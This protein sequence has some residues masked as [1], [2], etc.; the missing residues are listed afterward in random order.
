MAI[1]FKI[2]AQ[3]KS[4]EEWK[5]FKCKMHRRSGACDE[6]Q[7]GFAAPDA[8][9]NLKVGDAFEMI[10]DGVRRFAGTVARLP[11]KYS[12]KYERAELVAKSP[13]GDLESVVFQQ[14]WMKSG[15]G[16]LSPIKRSKV[17]LGQ[18]VD[19]QKIGVGNQLR[20]ILEYAVSCGANISIGD[21]SLDAPMLLDEAKDLSCS[22]AI[23]RVLKWAP[24]NI[25]Y[26]DYSAQGAPSINIKRRGA[27][28]AKTL[29]TNSGKIKDV[30]ITPRED[31]RISGVSVKYE[32]ENTAEDNTWLD[33]V[34]DKY[35][36]DFNSTS[37]N[38]LVMSVELAGSKAFCQSYKIV[39]ETIQPNSEAWWRK[40]V[41]VLKEG[42][43]F[44]VVSS[45]RD[46]SSLPR[47]LVSGSISSRMN[48]KTETDRV[49]ATIR[50][51]DENGSISTREIAVRLVATNA[52]TGTYDI[53]TASQY[54]EPIPTGL[55]KAIYDA[56]G[57]L[58]FDGQITV[59]G[60][61]SED[62]MGFSVNVQSA[63]NPGWASMNSAVVS[64]EE[65]VFKS[66]L[67]IKFGPPKHLYPDNIAELFRISRPRKVPQDA[68]SRSSG[69]VGSSRVQ[70]DGLSPDTNGAQGDSKYSRMVIEGD[71]E[72]HGSIDLNSDSL[73]A[74]EK[75]A[76][77]EILLCK[78]GKLAKAKVIMT[79]PVFLEDGQ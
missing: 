46:D 17:V 9:E 18:S 57:Q 29:A 44:S 33:V 53:W 16:G 52:S 25:I 38:A 20:E 76:I 75:I 27:L 6:M 77:R 23:A 1:I 39:C 32:T 13:W 30:S 79:D 71:I 48:F 69:K 70:L 45:G 10:E 78:D 34:E 28:P 49:Y 42:E 43:S 37:K 47:E 58:L 54:A 72:T 40:R 67:K 2:G 62:F 50:Y 56:A 36:V 11:R 68:G 21:I 22:E 55:A 7:L 14:D 31:L 5:I 35:P 64:C 59:V 19:G 26:F 24:D 73:S 4:A 65:D 12:G 8:A 60:G 63:E 41:P 15:T 61:K 3:T 74:D 51:I 66:L